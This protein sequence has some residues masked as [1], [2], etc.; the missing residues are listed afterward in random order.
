MIIKLFNSLFIAIIIIYIYF[1]NNLLHSTRGQTMV[2]T[3]ITTYNRRTP[4]M[5]LKKKKKE[6]N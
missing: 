5:G 6:N 2:A 4:N 1:I 3:F